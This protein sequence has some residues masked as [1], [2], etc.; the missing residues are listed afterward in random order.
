MI[1]IEVVNNSPS[2]EDVVMLGIR[3]RQSLKKG[4]NLS[5]IYNDVI[6]DDGSLLELI[7]KIASQPIAILGVRLRSELV[8]KI[9]EKSILLTK[10]AINGNIYQESLHISEYSS[11][12]DFCP[13]IIHIQKKFI[14]DYSTSI[15]ITNIMP[16]ERLYLFLYPCDKI[17]LNTNEHI[18][19]SIKQ[20]SKIK[21]RKLLLTF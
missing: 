19:N 12:Y 4:I 14:L 7:S 8:Y 2:I 1:G 11:P 9:T 15:T 13:S 3:H 17:G 10:E 16:A 6:Y 5:S 18:Y 21:T 20:L